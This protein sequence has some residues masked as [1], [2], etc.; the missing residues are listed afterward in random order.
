MDS[1]IIVSILGIFFTAFIGAAVRSLWSRIG[2]SVSRQ[3]MDKEVN[4]IKTELEKNEDK[5]T[6]GRKE[7][8]VEINQ[9]KQDLA[10]LKGRLEGKE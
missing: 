7:M 3:E 6:A 4:L 2:N 9:V 10:E 5:D 1:A 8:W